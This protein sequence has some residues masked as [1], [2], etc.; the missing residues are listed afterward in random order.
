M[1]Y[2]TAKKKL[3]N[4]NNP[5]KH[6]FT[7]HLVF[8]IN[9]WTYFEIHFL[10]HSYYFLLPRFEFIHS[11]NVRAWVGVTFQ[12]I[13]YQ[14]GDCFLAYFVTLILTK[15]FRKCSQFQSWSTEIL[16]DLNAFWICDLIFYLLIENCSYTLIC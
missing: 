14:M 2:C 8:I 5:W 7:L 9:T 1:W 4:I 3:T 15:Y 10:I 12:T 13:S 16:F 6:I 11:A